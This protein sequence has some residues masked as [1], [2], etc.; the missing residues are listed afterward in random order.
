MTGSFGLT[1]WLQGR[2]DRFGIFFGLEVGQAQ[3]EPSRVQVE[4]RS[5]TWR[6]ALS[7]LANLPALT[8]WRALLR[9][10]EIMFVCLLRMPR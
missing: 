6:Y 7:T 8:N 2:F 1:L 4:S 5:K 3:E 10:S 9:I